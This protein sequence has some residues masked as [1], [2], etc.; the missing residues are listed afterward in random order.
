MRT[1][2]LAER[3]AEV[4]SSLRRLDAGDGYLRAVETLL[5][6]VADELANPCRGRAGQILDDR[7]D[8]VDLITRNP[9]LLD[10]SA[11]DRAVFAA[12]SERVADDFELEH[13]RR[14]GRLPGLLYHYFASLLD[15]LPPGGLARFKLSEP[16]AGR[17]AGLTSAEELA[18]LAAMA[19]PLRGGRT[20]HGNLSP[21]ELTGLRKAEEFYGF[22]HVRGV[23]N[24]H[25]EAFASGIPVPPLFVVSLPGLGKTA[26]T[27]AYTLRHENL[28]LILPAPEQLEDGLRPLLDKLAA[29]RGHRF[30]LFFDDI[31]PREIKWYHF[32]TNIGGIFAAPPNVACVIAA[33]FEFPVNVLS[34][35]RGVAF[36]IFD[37]ISCQ[38]MIHD[39]LTQHFLRNPDKNLV[40]VMAADYVEEFGQKKFTELSPRTLVRYLESYVRDPKKRKKMLEASRQEM[41][42]R[43][44]AQLFY[45]QNIK[46]M[47]ALYGDGCIEEMLKEKLR[48]LGGGA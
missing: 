14:I 44:D 30:V 7:P 38:E 47:R 16:A 36:P 40:S 8:S 25:F 26:L 29:A 19:D 3:I 12:C 23:F 13:L 32:R 27:V 2:E 46:M 35:G 11:L 33:N 39:F 6:Q 10:A 42:I 4:R 28:T 24:E 48:K 37:E 31:D 34:R 18:R 43:P 22:E 20:L 45:E 9:G 15:E 41:I 21:L 5:V 1:S 17:L